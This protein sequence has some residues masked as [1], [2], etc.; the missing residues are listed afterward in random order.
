MNFRSDKVK[1]YSSF[2]AAMNRD[3][4]RSYKD[5]ML[6]AEMLA[7]QFSQGQRTTFI[8]HAPG[9]TDDLIDSF[10]M[11][12]YFFTDDDETFNFYALDY[13]ELRE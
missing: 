6:K 4:I 8:E 10:L 5:D 13:E 7:L 2:R 3:I 9:Y 11:S 1:K 12:A